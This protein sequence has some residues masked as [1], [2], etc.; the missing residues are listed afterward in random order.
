M[1]K[2]V[3]MITVILLLLVLLALFCGCSKNTPDDIEDIP[4]EVTII[5]DDSEAAGGF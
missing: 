2:T 3:Q 1:K 4:E 5:I